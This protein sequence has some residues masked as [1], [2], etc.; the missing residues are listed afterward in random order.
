MV[1]FLL[2]IRQNKW[3]LYVATSRTV[4]DSL[5]STMAWTLSGP[6]RV[7]FMRHASVALPIARSRRSSAVVSN[8]LK[9]MATRVPRL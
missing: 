6:I 3:Y 4:A 2:V 7:T 8:S 5:M 1:S 9:A